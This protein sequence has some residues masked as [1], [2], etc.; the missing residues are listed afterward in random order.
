MRAVQAATGTNPE[1]FAANLNTLLRERAARTAADEPRLALAA[2][3][4]L[5]RIDKVLDTSGRVAYLEGQRLSDIMAPVLPPALPS[6]RRQRCADCDGRREAMGCGEG[7]PRRD[8]AD[9]GHGGGRGVMVN[10]QILR[11]AGAIAGHI[12]HLTVD[13][14]GP[15]CICG[16]R[17]CLETYFSALAIESAARRRFIEGW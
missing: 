16:N 8:D 14:D 9:T 2:K 6:D 3:G 1:A 10:G 7:L 17:G 12:G 4:S 5:M 15:E 13:P 11:G